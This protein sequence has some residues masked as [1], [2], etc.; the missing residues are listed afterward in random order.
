[1]GRAGQ[2]RAGVNGWCEREGR[3]GREGEHL[4]TPL[5]PSSSFFLPSIPAS[6]Q[7]PVIVPE[8]SP[9]PLPT[10][11]NCAGIGSIMAWE[12]RRGAKGDGWRVRRRKGEGGG[13]GGGG[14]GKVMYG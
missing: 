8:V 12:E 10:G 13:G 6:Q 2:G 11:R 4:L 5:H 1:M 9:T 7:F 14:D 3:E